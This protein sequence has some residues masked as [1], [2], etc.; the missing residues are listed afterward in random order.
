MEVYETD[1][2]RVEAIKKWWKENGMSL[3]SGLV[4]GISALAGWNLWTDHKQGISDQASMVYTRMMA[5]IAQGKPDQTQTSAGELV[6]NFSD[7]PYAIHAALAM[8][9]VKVEQGEVVAATSQLRWALD[10]ASQAA[11]QH[12]ARLRLT[13]V[14]VAQEKHDAAMAE[15]A[16]IDAGSFKAMYEELRG[17]ILLGQGKNREAHEAFRSA[18]NILEP[19]SRNRM[20]LQMKIDS[21]GKLDAPDIEIQSNDKDKV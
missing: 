13:R 2:E 16:G 15:L 20:L 5:S 6:T 7:S 12:I 3:V 1:D 4:I 19:T 17:D 14:L 8:A 21:I 11:M 9:K 10:H 18:L